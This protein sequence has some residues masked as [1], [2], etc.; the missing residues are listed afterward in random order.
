M[1][2]EFKIIASAETEK[3]A[4]DITKFTNQITKQVSS[5]DDAFI[6]TQNQLAKFKTALGSATEPGQVA[7]LRKNIELLEGRLAG[8]AK[9]A[10]TAGVKIG[11]LGE[12]VGSAIPTL[13]NFGRVIQ[14]AP[15]GIIGIANN[16]DP[17]ISS[18]QSLRASSTST[19][20]ALKSLFSAL[21][22]P[23]GIAIGV[24][25]VT[26]A[27]I[28]FGPEI[29]SAIFGVKELTEEE[30]KLAEKNR[31]V[32]ESLAT[33][34]IKIQS[35]AS[36]ANDELRSK[37]DR[38]AAIEELRKKYPEYLQGLTN[39]E[40]LSKGVASATDAITKSLIRR[41]V[42]EAAREK[43]TKEVADQLEKALSA[44]KA[45]A[46]EAPNF[47]NA[48]KQQTTANDL[49]VQ[50][51]TGAANAT[52]FFEE[53][54][55]KV[56]SAGKIRLPTAEELSGFGSASLAANRVFNKVQKSIQD[57][58]PLFQALGGSVNDFAGG[59]GKADKVATSQATSLKNVSDAA[60]SAEFSLDKLFASIGT[61]TTGQ[62]KAVRVTTS[63]T[64]ALVALAK[65]ADAA[66]LAK[67]K[68]AALD[69]QKAL[70]GDLPTISAA[71]RG[72]AKAALD[73]NDAFFK[74]GD[75]NIKN[76]DAKVAL[77]SENLT[78]LFTGAFQALSQGESPIQAITQ[79]LKQLIVRLA[80]AA[81]T[82]AVLSLI[83]GG[84]TGGAPVIA[85]AANNSFGGIFKSLLGL[86]SGGIASRPTPALIGD[87]GPEAVI[88][89]SQ[90]ANIIGGVAMQMGGG[91]GN[92]SIVR[93]QDIYYS[94]NN[95]SRSF[96]RLFG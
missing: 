89:L 49:Y 32:A 28:A 38:V 26:S 96:G 40:A 14:D 30:K 73:A 95:A 41:I 67:Q 90:L 76:F 35:L 51:L 71:G 31:E 18:F 24:S 53:S 33:E 79:S 87:G 34:I 9:Q 93:G 62:E 37:K 19:G 74:K 77:A 20:A 25:A 72:P 75:E 8:I 23:A 92:L 91:G 55:K 5:I 68:T 56:K 3:A 52:E 50:S 61:F 78:G 54:V 88:P 39:E 86:A 4:A 46:Q 85:G 58:I 29:A 83:L 7:F 47:L 84:I 43:I 12:S 82:A 6:S 59:F 44:E 60:E 15:F 27:L 17:L 69:K 11:G 13:T 2:A 57:I 81:A 70:G 1:A 16:I 65:A 80:A 45:I 42:L 36:V 10:Q 66:F 64:S 48:T 21:A 94:N 22:G 63:E